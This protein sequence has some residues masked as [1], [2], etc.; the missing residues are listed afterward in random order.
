MI[1]QLRLKEPITAR[2][3]APAA[4]EIL[5]DCNLEGAFWVDKPNADTLHIDRFSFRENISLTYSIKDQKLKAERQ[6]MPW[7]QV[8]IRMHFRGGYEQSK[9]WNKLWGL[10]LCLQALEAVTSR[11]ITLRHDE[12]DP[13]NIM[14][15]PR[16]C[17]AESVSSFAVRGYRAQRW[18]ARVGPVAANQIGLELQL[19]WVP[20]PRW[21]VACG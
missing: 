8:A 14:M 16:R 9:F 1:G 15:R 2:S 19:T 21:T 11:R 20:R 6:P 13:L 4:Q 17:Q 5:K 12:I 18:D 10:G 7:S 3:C